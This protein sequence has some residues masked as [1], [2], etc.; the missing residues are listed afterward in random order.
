MRFRPSKLWAGFA[1]LLLSTQYVQARCILQE[2][3]WSL[4]VNYER[5]MIMNPGDFCERRL[6]FDGRIL[7]IKIPQRPKFGTV[8]LSSTNYGYRAPRNFVGKDVFV[9]EVRGQHHGRIDATRFT[10]HVEVRR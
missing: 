5:Q 4:G 9:V 10:V 1:L 6:T 2:G 3:R 7:S 8:A